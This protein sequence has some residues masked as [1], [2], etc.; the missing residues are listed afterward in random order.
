MPD[1]EVDVH[2]VA[3]A[4]VAK[5]RS[6]PEGYF[7]LGGVKGDRLF[8]V[9]HHESYV[10]ASYELP[11]APSH[12][13]VRLLPASSVS[14][15]VRD[16]ATGAPVAGRQVRLRSEQLASDL[17]AISAEDG[18]FRFDRV[19][20]GRWLI[21]ANSGGSRSRAVPTI[22]V[23]VAAVV[24]GIDL[25]I[26]P[27]LAISGWVGFAEGGGHCRSGRVELSGDAYRMVTVSTDG[28]FRFEGLVAGQY[29]VTPACDGFRVG[30]GLVVRLDERS[31]EDVDL[32]VVSGCTLSG[33]IAP[34]ELATSATLQVEGPEGERERGHF[35]ISPDGRFEVRGLS[36]EPHRLRFSAGLVESEPVSVRCPSSEVVLRAPL[37]TARI[38]GEI[39]SHGQALGRLSLQAR[40][41]G[42]PGVERRVAPDGRFRLDDVPTGT[43]SLALYRGGVH[44]IPL[45]GAPNGVWTVVARPGEERR[46]HLAL[47]EP[48]E[49][50]EVRGRVTTDDGVGV[51]DAVIFG[52]PTGPVGLGRSV[53]RWDEGGGTLV[54]RA[55][56]DAKGHFSFRAPAERELRLQVTAVGYA[57]EE[58]VVAPER[59]AGVILH[60][61]AM[62]SGRVLGE[63][64]REVRVSATRRGG[65]EE[66]VTDLPPGEGAWSFADLAPGR[67]AF[68]ARG[69]GRRGEA[70]A[71]LGAGE[72]R[73]DL[74]L[75]LL[76]PI[77]LQGR[78]LDRETRR[79]IR[80][81]EIFASADAWTWTDDAGQFELH[82][83]PSQHAKFAVARDRPPLRAV[84]D[85]NLP[86]PCDR[87]DLGEVLVP[88][89]AK[90][91]A[92]RCLR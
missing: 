22:E 63:P 21:S 40:I 72:V 54:P 26:S 71:E 85:V 52:P 44:P 2:D 4:T 8:V 27:G 51:P 28:T 3:G 39:S 67:W 24:S 29:L 90:A 20:P 34:V 55:I 89:E 76:R 32:V 87:V 83:V 16:A 11:V 25:E 57:P 35:P 82:G 50:A 42:G 33:H 47:D 36:P 13:E 58:L 60:R 77:V 81:A 31:Q 9:V 66:E 73:S 49:D 80:G 19:P 14:G 84:L 7:R 45:M 56:A 92:G 68:Q 15:R 1:A 46:V 91:P 12:T 23:G 53:G 41:T 75:R 79:P 62:V 86:Y 64:C 65:L 78:L 37:G 10:E 18:S 59:P 43:V 38:V 6:S 17:S 5:A 69:C 48:P 70:Q 61:P 30:R 88:Q 74:I